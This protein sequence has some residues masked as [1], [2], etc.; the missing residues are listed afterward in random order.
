MEAIKALEPGDVIAQHAWLFVPHVTLPSRREWSTDYETRDAYLQEQRNRAFN[1][2]MSKGP[3]ISPILA[4]SATGSAD[5]RT[6]GLTFADRAGAPAFDADVLALPFN[7]EGAHG[8]FSLAFLSRRTEQEGVPWL[9]GH[10]ETL[11]KE[12]RSSDAVA[13]ITC[14][15]SDADI[16]DWISAQPAAFQDCYWKRVDLWSP[17]VRDDDDFERIVTGIL[18]AHRWDQAIELLSDSARREFP[19]GR[20]LDYIRILWYPR[21][22]GSYED[23]ATGFRHHAATYAIPKTFTYLDSCGGVD[24]SE[25]AELEI[26]YSRT[27]EHSEYRIKHLGKL[28]GDSASF[29]V[30]MISRMFR[31]ATEVNGQADV[32]PLDDNAKQQ[33]EIAF[34]VSHLWNGYPGDDK[35]IDERNDILKSWC[36]DVMRLA[37]ESD[38]EEIGKEK[39]GE[40]LARVPPDETDGVWPC[41]VARDYL[42]SGIAEIG[43]GLSIARFNGRGVTCR[44]LSEGGRQEREVADAYRADADRIRDNYPRTAALIDSDAQ[45]LLWYADRADA[46]AEQF[47]D[48]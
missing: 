24:S 30:D 37:R 25:L 42:E 23:V 45:S 46:D 44:S 33:A 31:T 6:V 28:L 32:A 4:L 18:N 26:Y 17:G 14:A 13:A 7:N 27:L 8:A 15:G 21:D 35:P 48:P 20:P 36:D 12:G 2:I 47:T 16:R 1:S 11:I 40:V 9:I 39:V 38:R 29:F 5:P 10:A 22:G 19:N 41:L 43:N 34:R 3:D